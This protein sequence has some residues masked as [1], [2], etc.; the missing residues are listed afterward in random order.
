MAWVRCLE[1]C[2][3]K[4]LKPGV[5]LP[6]GNST[7]DFKTK[8]DAAIKNLKPGRYTT[9]CTDITEQDTTKT[10]AIHGVIKSLFRAIGTPE[11]VIDV[12][13]FLVEELDCPRFRLLPPRAQCLPQRHFDDVHPQH[14]G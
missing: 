6:N 7:K 9:L 12:L 1:L 11:K 3:I 2:I 4:A 8:M 14:P 5:V 10:P 13:F